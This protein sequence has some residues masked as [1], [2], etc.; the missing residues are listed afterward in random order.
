VNATDTRTKSEALR[1]VGLR[2]ADT[3]RTRFPGGPAVFESLERERAA[4]SSLIAGGLA[5]RLFLWLVPFGLV[6]AA[7]G[8]FWADSDR[9]GIVK[10]VR[11]FG[12]SG[13]A[14]CNA[15]AAF[16]DCQHSRWYLLAV[17]LVLLLWFGIGAVRALLVSHQVAWA[18]HATKLRNPLGASVLFTATVVAVS[19]VGIGCQWVRHNESGWLGASILLVMFGVYALVA[20]SAMSLLPHGGAPRLAL[21]PGALLAGVG[22]IFVQAFVSVYLAPKLERQPQLYG[23]LG[24]ATVILLWLYI[25][26]RLIVSAAFLNATLWDRRTRATE[27][28]AGE[29]PAGV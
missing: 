24:G 19:A 9:G 29:V 14:A 1:A 18:V 20:V 28:A 21:L 8:S 22:M 3:A 15:R 26:A 27:D 17:G 10:T 7:M 13:A 11:K 12:I 6:L 23:A 25:I 16:T 5:Y 4:G 2:A